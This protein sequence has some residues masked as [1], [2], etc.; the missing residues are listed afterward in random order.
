MAWLTDAAAAG[1]GVDVP[2]SHP[3]HPTVPCAA[4]IRWNAHAGVLDPRPGLT[5]RNLCA[6]VLACGSI[7]AAR[8]TPLSHFDRAPS[9]DQARE[10]IQQAGDRIVA[11]LNEPG[12]WAA[13]AVKLQEMMAEIMDVSGISRFALGRFWSTASGAQRDEFVRLFPVLLLGQIGR[14]VSVFQGT[15]FTIDRTIPHEGWV[16]VWTTVYR[17][18]MASRQVE[19]LVASADGKLRII[20]ILAEATSLRITEREDVSSFLAQ[21]GHSLDLLLDAL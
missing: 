5:R 2:N 14:S 3:N 15:T 20:D 6:L 10:F 7:V 19:W 11:V 16:E 21:H 1:S 13:K 4:T 8:A 17:P 9:S 18:R 12:D